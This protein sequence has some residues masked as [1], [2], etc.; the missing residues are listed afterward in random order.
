MSLTAEQWKVKK[1]G[2]TVFGPI[3]SETVRKWIREQRVWSDDLL[4]NDGDDRWRP[5]RKVPE[6]AGAFRLLE[7]KALHVTHELFHVH[8]EYCACPTLSTR[9]KVA[10]AA[11]V[12]VSAA[13][14]YVD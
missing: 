12:A 2:G 13:L 14:L 4:S 3:R 7:D 9:Q 5:A 6:F 11:A 8:P 1:P 10:L